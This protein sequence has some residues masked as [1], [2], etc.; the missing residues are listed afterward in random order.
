MRLSAEGQAEAPGSLRMNDRERL[1]QRYV[2]GELDRDAMRSCE[3]LLAG[4]P[5]LAER[6]AA[7][8]CTGSDYR[9]LHRHVP[10][11]AE[12]RVARIMEDLPQAV[13][14][15][16]SAWSLVDLIYLGVVVIMI[17]LG[18]GLLAEMPRLLPLSLVMVGSLL[19][20]GML[21]LL[22]EPLR[23]VETSLMTRLLR[24]RVPVRGADVLVVRAAGVALIIGAIWYRTQVGF[25]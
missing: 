15:R 8:E 23:Q 2:D 20:G 1:L 21:L 3:A 16:T 7:W 17:G 18:F 6:L 19:V 22:A 13:P 10:G 5:E 4:D 11:S 12:Q 25:G 14:A 9:A 24:R